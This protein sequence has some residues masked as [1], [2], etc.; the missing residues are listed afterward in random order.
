MF[1]GY[2]LKGF[3]RMKVENV[4]IKVRYYGEMKGKVKDG[5]S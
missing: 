3:G 4:I 1:G 2:F 5:Y